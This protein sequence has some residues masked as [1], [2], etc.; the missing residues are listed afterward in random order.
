MHTHINVSMINVQML[1]QVTIWVLLTYTTYLL[2]YSEGAA[3]RPKQ[4]ETDD[5][6]PYLIAFRRHDR[7]R[8]AE[9]ERL[10]RS[11]MYFKPIDWNVVVQPRIADTGDS[12]S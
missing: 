11:L 3:M 6:S 12:S 2:S 8:I 4:I 9:Y 10:K 1:F 5:F 7:S